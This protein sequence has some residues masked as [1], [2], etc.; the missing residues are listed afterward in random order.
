MTARK[1]RSLC[2]DVP[3]DILDTGSKQIQGDG[4]KGN[5]LVSVAT[6]TPICTV[7]GIDVC[8][9]V[10]KLLRLHKSKLAPCRDLVRLHDHNKLSQ[11]CFAYQIC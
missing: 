2:A 4:A 9:H 6:E 3:P 7:F 10:E 8:A 5:L 1:L 11:A